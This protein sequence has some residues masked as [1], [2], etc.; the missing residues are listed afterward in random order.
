MLSAADASGPTDQTR[1]L[2][3]TAQIA[4]CVR[5]LTRILRR[6]ALTWTFTVASA[7]LIL[8]A[9]LLLGQPSAIQRRRHF[10]RADSRGVVSVPST[11]SASVPRPSGGGASSIP[12][13]GGAP[14]AWTTG[15]AWSCQSSRSCMNGNS[16]GGRIVSPSMTNSI[17]LKKAPQLIAFV[18]QALAP[19]R[20][21]EINSSR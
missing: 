14:A 5:L 18:K 4:A 10:P 19:A 17:V 21:A 6:I 8:R 20:Y 15:G 11:R 3:L 1:E 7:I 13:R 16:S 2:L 9:V 12:C